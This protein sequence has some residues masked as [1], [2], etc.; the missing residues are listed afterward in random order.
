MAAVALAFGAVSVLHSFA[1]AISKTAPE[2]S[3]ALSPSDGRVGAL[4]AQNL[5]TT[6]TGLAEHE[7]AARIARAA[8]IREPLAV[9]AVVALAL[10]AELR[11]KTGEARRLF[12][13]SDTI[14]RREL[15]TRMWLIEDAVQRGNIPLAVHN[16][17]IALRTSP[18]TFDL[19]F[20][21]LAGGI[22]DPAIAAA[23]MSTLAKRPVWSENFI[24]YMS[25]SAPDPKRTANF[26]RLLSARGILV[27]TTEQAGIV[28]T[29]VAANA[30]GDAWDYYRTLRHGVDRRRSRD[31]EFTEQL[32]APTAFDWTPR[33]TD[34]GITA[35]IQRN[36][37]NGIFDFSAPSIVGGIVLEQ[38]QLLPAGRYR[39]RGRSIGIDQ[40]L[41]SAPYWL[42]VCTD[43]RELG[44]IAVTNSSQ[45]NGWFNGSFTVNDHCPAQ[46]L[47]LIVRPSNATSG[48]SGQLES[49]QLQPL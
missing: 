45:D 48:V 15:S 20:P 30:F 25:N 28:N 4:F 16:Y 47:R 37:K 43:G 32:N 23:L 39:L 6:K 7:T 14:S 19:L 12:M 29:L 2:S 35:S 18:R 27:G 22:A 1:Y 46:V 17:D 11:G 49:V 9:S 38:L 41:D 5:L 10:D 8:L 21:L 42:L 26:F 36:G 40:A 24:R 34:P 33:M 31:A 3:Y 44:R 13:H